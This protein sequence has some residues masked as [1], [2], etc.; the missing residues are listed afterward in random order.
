MKSLSKIPELWIDVQEKSGIIR[1]IEA[2]PELFPSIDVKELG[3]FDPDTDD[4]IQCG[5]FSNANRSFINEHKIIHT[6][7]KDQNG[8]YKEGDFHPSLVSG[9][10]QDQLAKMRIYYKTNRSFICEG[11]LLNYGIWHPTLRD[12]AYSLVGL[13]T[14]NDISF[15]ECY[16]DE[17][18]LEKLYWIN[19]KSGTASV[20]RT[21]IRNTGR[22]II[23][24]LAS[25]KNVPNIG[26]GRAKLLFKKYGNIWSIIENRGCLSRDNK[27]IGPKT[28]EAFINWLHD[29]VIINDDRLEES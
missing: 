20:A 21:E 27:G 19:R 25:F 22:F 3:F 8:K 23:P 13:C 29:E 5:D 1:L 10:T 7:K 26:I 6:L 18:F 15:V 14:N 2:H 12:K 11:S 16:N 4:Y 9:R 24:Q 17:D 28:Q